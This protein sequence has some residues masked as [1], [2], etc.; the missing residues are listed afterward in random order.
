M[1][2]LISILVL[3]KKYSFLRNNLKN[4]IGFA[5]LRIIERDLTGL[6]GDQDKYIVQ[7]FQNNEVIATIG[8]V[9]KKIK[10]S[11]F[12]NYLLG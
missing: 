11:E 5:E 1:E 8:T 10:E 3:N 7:L 9:P 4:R 2:N 12:I 6:K